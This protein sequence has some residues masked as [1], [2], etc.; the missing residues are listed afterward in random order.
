MLCV[1]YSTLSL[2]N[3]VAILREIA[4]HSAYE[5]FSLYQYVYLTYQEGLSH[6]GF[7]GGILVLIVLV[8]DHAYFYLFHIFYSLNFLI[9]LIPDHCLL[10]PFH[11]FT[12]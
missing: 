12:I 3:R 7:Y 4:A 11:F 6:F 8:H 2:G 9:V 1:L 10:L 5:T